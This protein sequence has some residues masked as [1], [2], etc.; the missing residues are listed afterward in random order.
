[1]NTS[2]ENT[3]D[4]EI[5]AQQI[6]LEYIIE[7]LTSTFD[8][9]RETSS[10]NKQHQYIAT[11]KTELMPILILEAVSDGYTSIWID[12]PQSPWTNDIECA[13]DAFK[14]LQT[15]I[16]CIKGSWDSSEDPDLWWSISEKGENSVIW[17]TQ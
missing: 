12:S 7:W 3:P 1:M 13:R 2:T 11:W 4:I 10:R 9:L 5:Y 15:E 17:K 6:K 16:R 8:N 14:I